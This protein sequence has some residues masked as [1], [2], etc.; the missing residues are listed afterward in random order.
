MQQGANPQVSDIASRHLLC[1]RFPTCE[2]GTHL[3]LRGPSS[4][5]QTV[6]SDKH[7]GNGG[8]TCQPKPLAIFCL[9]TM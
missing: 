3:N 6:H 4:S 8:P 1:L 2:M 5:Y 9:N 7:S